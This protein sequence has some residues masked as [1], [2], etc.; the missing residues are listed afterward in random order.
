MV[1]CWGSC[2]NLTC[3]V[4]GEV[5]GPQT[6]AQSLMKKQVFLVE[7]NTHTDRLKNSNSFLSIV[8]IAI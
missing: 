1:T 3:A 4:L 5:E 2:Y 6:V 7:V 8:A